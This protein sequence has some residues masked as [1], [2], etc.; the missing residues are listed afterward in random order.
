MATSLLCQQRSPENT[1]NANVRDESI[2]KA[3]SG[4]QKRNK[5]NREHMK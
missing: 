2:Q 3:E 5:E 1:Q 4:K